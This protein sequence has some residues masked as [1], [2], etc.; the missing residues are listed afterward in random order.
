MQ[1]KTAKQE[2]R[3]P[4][5]L[6]ASKRKRQRKR[7]GDSVFRNIRENGKAIARGEES[8]GKQAQLGITRQEESDGKQEN[9]GTKTAE[10]SD[11]KY[12][13]VGLPTA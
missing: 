11:G 10:E 12:E 5:S 6:T 1:T 3:G 8:N 2:R 13:K 9:V 7:E 4:K